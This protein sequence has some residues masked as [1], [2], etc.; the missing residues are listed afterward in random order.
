MSLIKQ[1]REKAQEEKPSRTPVADPADTPSEPSRENGG[2][3]P[4]R[5]EGETGLRY[6]LWTVVL[7]V[8]SLLISAQLTYL[9]LMNL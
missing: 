2:E 1:A 8:L 7:F 6:W 5:A 9:V 4:D 3:K